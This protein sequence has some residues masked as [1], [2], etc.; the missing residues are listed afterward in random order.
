MGPLVLLSYSLVLCILD[1]IFMTEGDASEKLAHER[2]YGPRIEGTAIA[3]GIHELLE[4]LLAV[5]KDQ[6]QFGFRVDDIV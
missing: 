5:L 3:I 1:S 6:D 2:L 4:V